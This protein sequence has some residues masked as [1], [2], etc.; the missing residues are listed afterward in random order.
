LVEKR[1]GSRAFGGVA[2]ES[3][4]GMQLAVRDLLALRRG[5][6]DDRM[7]SSKNQRSQSETGN[8]TDAGVV[9]QAKQVASQMADQTADLLS[10]HVADQASKSASDLGT[11]AEA[12]RLT[13]K[14]LSG[15][16]ASPYVNKAADQIERASHFLEQAELRDVVQGV[17]KFARREPALFLGG[18]FALGLVGARFLKS[19]APAAEP[20]AS[21]RGTRSTAGTGGGRQ[22]TQQSARDRKP[23]SRRGIS[24]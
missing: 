24:S 17:E 16:I 1:V 3:G 4:D 8:G 20:S 6:G 11:L 22:P 5:K 10:S 21:G 2:H 19:S 13:S 12:L 15:N 18:A 23:E 7:E 14:Q 9:G